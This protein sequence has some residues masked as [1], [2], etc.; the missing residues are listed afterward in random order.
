MPVDP[1]VVDVVDTLGAGDGLHGALLAAGRP[2]MGSRAYPAALARAVEAADARPRA[3]SERAAG[4][5]PTR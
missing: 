5:C 4:A 1:Q 2:I 3:R